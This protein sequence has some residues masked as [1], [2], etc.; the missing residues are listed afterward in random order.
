MSWQSKKEKHCNFSSGKKKSV[1]GALLGLGTLDDNR[2]LQKLLSGHE[3]VAENVMEIGCTGWA[4]QRE[5]F[6]WCVP[7]SV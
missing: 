2:E 3:C 6:S 1:R 4:H 7:L 5:K